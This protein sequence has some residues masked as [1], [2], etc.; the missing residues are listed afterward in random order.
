M[1][2]RLSLA[3]RELAVLLADERRLQVGLDLAPLVLLDSITA[4]S[5]AERRQLALAL[6]TKNVEVTSLSMQASKQEVWMKH[7]VP[8]RW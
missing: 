2:R 7:G 1:S 5:H 4:V 6:Q 8:D 3:L